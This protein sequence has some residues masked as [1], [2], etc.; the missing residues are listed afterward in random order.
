M[1]SRDDL[2]L[3][4]LQT[5]ID[6]TRASR[7]QAR[8]EKTAFRTVLEDVKRLR[9]SSRRSLQGALQDLKTVRQQVD[10]IRKDLK[11]SSS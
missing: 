6:E 7:D 10:A 11:D 9:A 3:D 1:R 5:V 4:G 8:V 2:R